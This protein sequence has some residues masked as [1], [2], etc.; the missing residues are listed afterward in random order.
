MEHGVMEHGNLDIGVVEHG[1]MEHGN[2]VKFFPINTKE[3]FS[4]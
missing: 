4:P 3:L 2:V 1:V